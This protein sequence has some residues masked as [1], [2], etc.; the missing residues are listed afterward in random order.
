MPTTTIDAT[1]DMSPLVSNPTQV[2]VNQIGAPV[3]NTIGVQY[4]FISG[5]CDPSSPVIGSI[6]NSAA[7]ST[8]EGTVKNGFASQ[9]GDPDAT[10]P[11]DSPIAAAIQTAL[12]GISIAGPVG[13]AVKAHLNAPSPPST[14]RRRGSTSAPTPTSTPPRATTRVT[15]PHRPEHPTCRTRSTPRASTRTSGGRHPRVIRSGS[16]W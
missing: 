13:D 7:G 1:F 16:A 9:L 2:D 10:G 6:V 5:K 12:S 15:A 8:I 3:V 14:S 11:A 4:E